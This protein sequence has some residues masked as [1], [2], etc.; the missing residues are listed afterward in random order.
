MVFLRYLLR[1]CVLT[2]ILA[3]GTL[4]AYTV[5][6]N[7][8]IVRLPTYEQSR[9]EE[10]ADEIRQGGDEA[11]LLP[12]S[13]EFGVYDPDGNFLYGTFEG[14]ERQEGWE[15]WK[16]GDTGAFYNIFYR[17][18]EKDDGNL[19]IVRYEMVAKFANSVLRE[20]FP[21]AEF[22]LLFIALLL[23][24][25]QSALTAKSF[26]RFL[27]RRLDILTEIAAKVGR[28]DLDFEREYSDIREVDDVL[29]AL[30]KM[31][32]A[33][34]RSLKEQWE[35]RRQ[36][37]EQ[38]AALAHDIKTPLTIIRG[39][40]ELMQETESMEE[41]REWDQEILDNAAELEGYLAVLHETVRMPE[42]RKQTKGRESAGQTAE[43]VIGQVADQHEE[44]IKPSEIRESEE[45]FPAGLFLEEVRRKAEALGRIKNL[46]VE[47]SFPKEDF[48]IR[49]QAG[50]RE[51]LM[52]AV[53]N[54]I[55]N[56]VD[57]S[58]A[59]QTLWICAELRGRTELQAQAGRKKISGQ[60]MFSEEKQDGGIFLQITVTDSGPGFS[61]EAL[62]HG[63]EQFYQ[64]DK[65]RAGTAHY[66]LGLYIARTV[67]EE[68]GGALE[69]GNSEET[70]GG[71]VR[72]Y[73]PCLTAFC[74]M[75]K[76]E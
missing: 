68:N 39:N 31:K 72:M 62:R 17:S 26:G 70:G 6:V 32:E 33:L 44:K 27:K 38:I 45:R 14:K 50:F 4:L 65:S 76:M 63:T 67:L 53:G 23:F 3:A 71:E 5:L 7:T 18:I 8:G 56:G 13:C 59:E 75:D 29:G 30:F 54:V 66:G 15:R 58:L 36:K 57:Y 10:A 52:R 61:K 21:N 20:I 55:S 69:V 2:V 34:Q 73:V 48:L 16:N 1:F 41:I 47:C 11:A 12:D 43:K 46:V 74:N 19:V 22:L 51:K 42:Q 37:Q 40:A 28:E 9:I 25:A 64:A 24:L 35:S 49:G 60:E